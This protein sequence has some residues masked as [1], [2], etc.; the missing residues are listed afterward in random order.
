MLNP[1]RTSTRVRDSMT[2]TT[3]NA[4]PI[5]PDDFLLNIIVTFLMPLFLTAGG[6]VAFAR[7]AAI[8]TVNAYRARNRADLITIA[9]IIACG[10]TALGSLGL[11][12]A[13]NL[14]LSMTLRLR[15]NAVALNRVV[16]QS[17]R[18][19]TQPQPAASPTAEPQFSPGS[20]A[21]L[22]EAEILAKLASVRELTTQAQPALP[23][24]EPP[25]PATVIPEPEPKAPEATQAEPTTDQEW[26]AHD[27]QAAWAAAMIDVAGE[28]TA[29]LDSLSPAQRAAA[30]HNA[31]ILA[32][33]AAQLIRGD[34]PPPPALG[35]LSA[36]IKSADDPRSTRCL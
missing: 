9:Q 24:V 32:D 26:Q 31:G 4:S 18:A 17:R 15:A 14:S 5:R 16:E 33:C 28:F 22:H 12:L 8:E 1:S 13:D 25:P 29:D 6:D 36:F 20:Q 7:I 2:E 3:A 11:S 30:A 35:D 34:V 27:L 19:L 21:A 10:L 23:N